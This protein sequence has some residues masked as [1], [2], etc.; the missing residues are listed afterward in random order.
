MR[1]LHK[2]INF[3][4]QIYRKLPEVISMSARN[5]IDVVQVLAIDMQEYNYI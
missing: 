5:G 2:Y 1:S 4:V 3:E